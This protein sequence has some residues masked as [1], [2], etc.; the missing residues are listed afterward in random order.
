[1]KDV[2]YCRRLGMHAECDSNPAKQIKLSADKKDR[3]GDPIA[4][5]IYVPTDFD[6]RTYLYSAKLFGEYA[7]ALGAVSSELGK[8]NEFVS[9]HHHMGGARMAARDR[10]GVLDGFGRVHGMA[11]LYVLGGAQFV[12][13]SAV[14]PTLTMVA[15]ALRATGD[16]LSRLG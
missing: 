12:T 7:A 2:P 14:N 13:S 10:D 3:F 6:H 15:L 4:H 16:L 5:V 11:N 1:M 9:G 8:E